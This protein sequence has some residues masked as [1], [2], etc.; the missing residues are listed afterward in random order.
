[1][2]YSQNNEEEIIGKFFENR[3]GGIFLDIGAY[4]G[5]QLSNTRKLLDDDKWSGVLVEPA[6]RNFLALMENMRPFCHKVDLV[7]AAVAGKSSISK[8]WIDEEPDRYWSTTIV[9]DLVDT[10]SVMKP[11]KYNVCIP[12]VGI[13]ELLDEFEDFTFISIDAE[14]KDFEILKAMPNRTLR[15]CELL[16]VEPRGVIQNHPERPL[17][18]KFLESLG[19]KLHAETLDNLLFCW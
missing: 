10:G 6:P 11:S 17:M 13:C 1:M 4:D 18:I 7:M 14:W 12:V 15:H 2:K 16:C 8:L 5:V 9:K 3:P 19:M